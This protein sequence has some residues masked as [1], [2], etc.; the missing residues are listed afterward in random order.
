MQRENWIWL[1]LLTLAVCWRVPAAQLE[2]VFDRLFDLYDSSTARELTGHFRLEARLL[3]L[4]NPDGLLGSGSRCDTVGPCDPVISAYI[5][6]ETASAVAG[7]PEAPDYIT[8]TPV[9]EV[10]D[11]NSPVINKVLSRDTCGRTIKKVLVRVHVVDHDRLS[12]EDLLDDFGCH[13]KMD[14]E[15][16]GNMELAEW[17]RELYCLPKSGLQKLRLSW[18]YR[19]FRVDPEDCRTMLSA[20]LAQA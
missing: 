20:T 16:A 17:S 15:P 1:V 11:E 10:R 13:V 4:E 12:S 2:G 9:L 18:K 6:Y 5:D 14:Q 19:F 7:T 8:Y 3:R